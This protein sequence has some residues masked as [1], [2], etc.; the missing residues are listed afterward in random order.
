MVN[1][2]IRLSMV[3]PL[4]LPHRKFPIQ[5]LLVRRLWQTSNGRLLNLDLHRAYTFEVNGEVLQVSLGGDDGNTPVAGSILL[6]IN[7]TGDL[8]VDTG[9]FYFEDG[10]QVPIVDVEDLN[11]AG[12]G[13]IDY[14][15]DPAF[16][17]GTPFE[18]QTVYVTNGGTTLMTAD[19]QILN[20]DDDG[21]VVV[22]QQQSTTYIDLTPNIPDDNITLEDLT[23]QVGETIMIDGV[24][25]TITVD[26]DN[27]GAGIIAQGPNGEVQQLNVFV[28]DDGS[29]SLAVD[30][31][32]DTQ[33]VEVN[34]TYYAVGGDGSLL[35]VNGN[36]LTTDPNDPNAQVVTA[37]IENGEVI[38]WQNADGDNLDA[39]LNPIVSLTTVSLVDE[40]G[41][42]YPLS[43]DVETLGAVDAEGNP[44]NIDY[45]DIAGVTANPPSN[46]ANGYEYGT[47]IIAVPNPNG[48][49]YI[50]ATTVTGPDGET[51]IV[52]VSVNENGEAEYGDVRFWERGEGSDHYAVDIYGNVI[53]FSIENNVGDPA[54]DGVEDASATYTPIFDEN[55]N[56]IGSTFTVTLIGENG[57]TSTMSIEQLHDESES[58]ENWMLTLDNP[59]PGGP[60]LI[61]E[62]DK[63]NGS[64]FNPVTLD[65]A[66]TINLG[67]GNGTLDTNELLYEKGSNTLYFIDENGDRVVL[68]QDPETGEYYP[69]GEVIGQVNCQPIEVPPSVQQHNLDDELVYEVPETTESVTI[70]CDYAPPIVVNSGEVVCVV[71][72]EPETGEIC[73][74]PETGEVSEINVIAPQ[75]D[76]IE[77]NVTGSG[78]VDCIFNPPMAPNNTVIVPMSEG[79]TLVILPDSGIPCVV[80]PGG[81]IATVLHPV[82]GEEVPV[83]AEVYA[84]LTDYNPELC[85]PEVIPPELP[86]PGD[87]PPGD[88]EPPKDEEEKEEEQ[89]EETGVP[90]ARYQFEERRRGD[91]EFLNRGIREEGFVDMYGV[92]INFTPE[93]LAELSESQMGHLTV[94]FESM[95]LDGA[96]AQRLLDEVDL[97]VPDDVVYEKAAAEG[98][99]PNEAYN[100][101]LIETLVEEGILLT[102][103][104]NGNYEVALNPLHPALMNI[105]A[106]DVEAVYTYANPDGFKF[107]I[108]ISPET[109]QLMVEQGLLETNVQGEL[110]TTAFAAERLGIEEGIT[111]N[112]YF[113]PATATLV[114][115]ILEFDDTANVYVQANSD[116]LGQVVTRQEVVGWDGSGPVFATVE[117][118]QLTTLGESVAR[119]A[120]QERGAAYLDNVLMEMVFENG[121]L[122]EIQQY[123]TVNANGTFEYNFDEM[124]EDRREEIV[125]NIQGF[126]MYRDAVLQLADD[127]AA[128]DPNIEMADMQ[129]LYV[130]QDLPLGGLTVVEEQGE[131]FIRPADPV[132]AT[133]IEEYGDM[134][135]SVFG[136]SNL[137]AS[138]AG[139]YDSSFGIP[140]TEFD[141]LLRDNPDMLED[142]QVTDPGLLEIIEE[143]TRQR[144]EHDSNESEQVANST[145]VPEF[146][147]T[148]RE[149]I[150]GFGG[151]LLPGSPEIVAQAQAFATANP[152]LTTASTFTGNSYNTEEVLDEIAETEVESEFSLPID[153]LA[154]QANIT[155]PSG[156]S[157]QE[158]QRLV[159]EELLNLPPEQALDS[160]LNAVGSQSPTMQQALIRELSELSANGQLSGDNAHELIESTLR[161]YVNSTTLDH[162][163][164]VMTYSPFGPGG[165]G[166]RNPE[167]VF[168]DFLA[169]DTA[170]A[171]SASTQV[172]EVE[173]AIE[174]AEALAAPPANLQAA[175]DRISYGDEVEKSLM[176][177]IAR[178]V[179]QYGP[180]AVT[181]TDIENDPNFSSLFVA[182]SNINTDLILDFLF[183]TDGNLN[184]DTLNDS[185]ESYNLAPVEAEQQDTGA[186]ELNGSGGDGDASSAED[187]D[188]EQQSDVAAAAAALNEF[189]QHDEITY[190]DA[191]DGR[192]GSR[193]WNVGGEDGRVSLAD[194][195]EI[196]ATQQDGEITE[197]AREALELLQS[198]GLASEEGLIVSEVEELINAPAGTTIS[199]EKLDEIIAARNGGNDGMIQ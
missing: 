130:N 132:N 140:L 24:E 165:E 177:N 82:T 9:G 91:E 176:T 164:Q 88:D 44:I 45:Q 36:P 98:I 2:S 28:G 145:Q 115:N 59:I 97:N 74:K 150:E 13:D 138:F 183:D 89:G 198:L 112:E 5:L 95:L 27:Q 17:E 37:V 195:L 172:G 125:S 161:S 86:P 35:D 68:G 158:Q 79:Q 58:I 141:Q 77:F 106:A 162:I 136:Q 38:G 84:E 178:I 52:P 133:L 31:G 20:I 15:V 135:A 54:F 152:E 182:D 10:Q 67:E 90:G 94:S 26:P 19:G 32:E 14:A 11:I 51:Y 143:V 65:T 56:A 156:L 39:N 64:G 60:P 127:I 41:N 25:Y 96:L 123:V 126:Q 99:S 131:Y 122:Q 87:N 159:L 69:A 129:I 153:V 188:E 72:V 101:M 46:L 21:N 168:N 80:N 111:L 154:A 108:D 148:L 107:D 120:I 81:T 180:D 121:E 105:Y 194:A 8:E 181:R 29:Y 102:E 163:V 55:G 119:A 174:E 175:L 93:E 134:V 73:I 155:I 104:V 53:G 62:M 33:Y 42:L 50:S 192:D 118:Y 76:S 114:D 157:T 75:A 113:V 173:D 103:E 190:H 100:L 110:V 128:T 66:I 116:Q 186:P 30:N 71:E 43:G 12:L 40:G 1:Y 83:N 171:Q 184:L 57:E 167:Q 151:L 124:P 193:T 170:N 47:E 109:Q 85:P 142:I 70:E 7:D 191:A 6:N 139:G 48:D 92:G 146:N 34:G 185:L 199:E 196:L 169:L 144:F 63:P 187:M 61:L 137:R 3:K 179:E 16:L 18:G 23:A 49:G 160:I 78:T 166:A 4:Q 117:E 149:F 147:Q 189:I 197:D 22:A